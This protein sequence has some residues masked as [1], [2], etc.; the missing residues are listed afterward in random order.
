MKAVKQGTKIVVVSLLATL[1]LIP[2]TLA[3]TKGGHQSA[4]SDV[5]YP[6]LAERVMANRMSF[7]VYQDADSGFN[8]GFPSGLFALNDALDKIHLDAACL[9]DPQSA[10]GCS[11]DM[12]RLDCVRGTGLRVSFDPL[13]PVEYAGVNIEE[14][15]QWGTNNRG[16]GYD[17]R[18]A[19]HLVLEARSPNARGTKIQFG[20]GGC[21]TDFLSIGRQWQEYR[22]ALNSLKD[23]E[24]L[25]P[26]SPNLVD[27]HVLFTVTTNGANARNGATVL[28]DNIRFEPVPTSQQS[29]LSFPLSTQTC[30][31]VPLQMEA[32]GRVPIPPDQVNRNVSTIY[33]AALTLLAFLARGTA[34]DL[35]H[36]RLIADTFVYALEHDNRGLPLPGAPDGLVGLHNAYECGDIALFNDQGPGA[37]QKGDVRLAGFSA[38]PQLC[39][40]SGFCLVLDGATGGNNAFAILTLVAAY[41]RFNDSHY[42]DA[43]RKIGRWIIVNLTDTTGT[44][45]GGYYLGY[46]DEGV[47]P[48]KPLLTGKSV[49]NNADIFSAFTALAAVERELNNTAQADEWTRAANVAGDFVMQMFDSAAG[50]FNAG[51][52]PPGTTGSGITPD[53]PQ[54]GNDVIN[55]FDFLD[56]NSFTTLALA[57]APR[58]RD[59]IDWRRPVQYMVDKFA[60]RIRVGGKEYHGF[61]IVEKPTAGP[62]GIAWEFTGQVVVVM[63]VV[64][65]L[66][67]DTRFE[68]M[69]NFYLDQ[70]CQ[71]LTMAPFGDGR[72]L[73]ASTLQEGDRLPP[74]EQC[75]STPFQCIPERVGLA[76]TTWAIFAERSFNPLSAVAISSSARKTVHSR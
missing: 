37:G 11:T 74:I 42:L 13:S 70:I 20:V 17:L 12:E 29:M 34:Q 28:L 65:R 76:A 47:P 35:S 10:T 59:Q 36:A 53:G 41:K 66:Y 33:E 61:N 69:A 30:G 40:P 25:T 56:S 32:L 1:M 7:Y 58:Y 72:G 71:A 45:Y 67:Q 51:T 31:V 55:T 62:N 60:Q 18:G 49:E 57:A 48:P 43:A 3:M 9:D 38:S 6:L 2:M 5:A 64:D 68:A 19:T 14:P 54:W 23:P 27:V 15:E 4:I 16:M 50:R 46:P 52:V 39:G 21:V 8:H 63:R 26:C 44:G 75:L 22:I 73:V 24:Y